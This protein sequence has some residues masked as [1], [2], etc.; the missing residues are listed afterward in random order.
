MGLAR[1]RRCPPPPALPIVLSGWD[2]ELWADMKSCLQGTFLPESASWAS[3]RVRCMPLC[4]FSVWP[5]PKLPSFSRPLE[6]KGRQDLVMERLA[7]PR[8]SWEHQGASLQTG[9]GT[10]SSCPRNRAQVPGKTGKDQDNRRGSAWVLHHTG[11]G[12]GPLSPCLLP[13]LRQVRLQ[14]PP[15]HLRPFLPYLLSAGNMDWRPRK[16]CLV[17]AGTGSAPACPGEGRPSHPSLP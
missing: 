2:C 17:F 10:E 16:A 9:S 8:A 14:V 3:G 4:F 12:L 13:P 7:S 6:S 11:R 15:G 1:L 5:S